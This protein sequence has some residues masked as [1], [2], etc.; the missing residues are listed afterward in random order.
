MV[1]WERQWIPRS[2]AVLKGHYWLKIYD[3]QEAHQS[4]RK[5]GTEGDENRG[6]SSD[7]HKRVV[8]PG[9]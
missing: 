4:A 3:D 5:E 8:F 2:V 1:S 9:E 7:N 6:K